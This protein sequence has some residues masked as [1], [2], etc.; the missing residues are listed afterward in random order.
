MARLVALSQFTTQP[1]PAMTTHINGNPISA[2]RDLIAPSGGIRSV[3]FSDGFTEAQ[4]LSIVFNL[5]RWIDESARSVEQR[6]I[7]LV[8]DLSRQVFDVGANDLSLVSALSG[9]AVASFES[10]LSNADTDVGLDQVEM[11][12]TELE[13]LDQ[14]FNAA[15]EGN[16]I[17]L[18]VMR[19]LS[20]LR[21]ILIESV[22]RGH[23]ILD[24]YT[25]GLECSQL[26]GLRISLGFSD[27]VQLAVAVLSV[28]VAVIGLTPAAMLP[29][30]LAT[31]GIAGASSVPAF[32][33]HLRNDAMRLADSSETSAKAL[34]KED[35]Y[36]T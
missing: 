33:Q 8:R 28:V 3:M 31:I 27:E 11:L 13:R 15:S 29:A 4:S 34:A 2:L 6:G 1:V 26:L 18:E 30:F 16:P 12:H 22:E 23:W 17:H 36:E 21:K 14:V 9:S 10:L 7:H 32:V 24:P 20:F 5:C 19:H 35:A 25:A